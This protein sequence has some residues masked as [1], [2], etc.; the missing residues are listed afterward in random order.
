MNQREHP[1][2]SMSSYLGGFP[3]RTPRR[4]IE[5]WVP[6]RATVLD[7]FCGSGTT[8]LEAK[9]L[10]RTAI[11]IDMN[12]LA[13]A[14]ARA[15]LASVSLDDVLFRLS[16]LA[17]GFRGELELDDV[18]ETLTPIFHRRTLAQLCYLR[19][20]LSSGTPEDAF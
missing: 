19:R 11:G 4:I 1:L 17:Q 10:G 3:P 9:L 20:Q 15:K 13:V 14:L 12:P 16:E 5:Q 7:P 8:L 18:P 2:H 6:K